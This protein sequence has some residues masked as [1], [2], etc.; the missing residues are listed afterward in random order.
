MVM[1]S[2]GTSATAKG[3]INIGPAAPLQLQFPNGPSANGQVGTPYSASLSAQGGIAPYMFSIS[4]GALPAGLTLSSSTG[5]ITGTPT[6]AAMGPAAQLK[7]NVVDSTGA[8][9]M[10]NGNINIAP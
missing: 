4:A 2:F 1:D 7:A 3:N 9:A 10:A 8:S 5:A 6:T